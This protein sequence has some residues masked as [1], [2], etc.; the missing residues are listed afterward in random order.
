[1]M[2]DTY[3]AIY[4]ATRS[5]ISGGNLSEVF[6]RAARDALD[7][8]NMRAIA[9]EAIGIVQ[10]EHTRPSVLYRPALLI[11]GDQWCALLGDNLHDGVAG[12]GD[13]PADA[14]AAFDQAFLKE[15][16]P[17]ARRQIAVD[18]SQFGVGA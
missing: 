11:D 9:I 10:G 14:M 12:F 16:T 4:D 3:Q 7:M 5:R 1:M 13:T 6:E 15:R 18:N 8:G 2:T 17:A